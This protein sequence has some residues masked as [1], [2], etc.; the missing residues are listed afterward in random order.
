MTEQINRQFLAQ[1]AR[2][3][4]E[5]LQKCSLQWRRPAI[6]GLRES[7]QRIENNPGW[8]ATQA[9]QD[10]FDTMTVIADSS[11][12]LSLVQGTAVF[13]NCENLFIFL[14]KTEGARV[15]LNN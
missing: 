15:R 6:D 2:L 8:T 1:T 7:F 9:L 12:D 3:S 11:T 14:T 10:H 4:I 13:K 5:A